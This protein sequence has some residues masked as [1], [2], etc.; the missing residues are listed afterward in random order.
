MEPEIS[1]SAL[2]RRL[3]A[4]GIEEGREEAR[5]LFSHFE[6]LPPSALYGQDPVS[7]S[8]ALLRA[9]AL[10][11]EGAPLAYLLGEAPFYRHTFLVNES[12]LIP[13]PE[14]ELL[15]ERAVSL[16]PKGGL[17]ADLGT[18]SGCIALSLLAERPDARAL[19]LDVSKGALAVA[20]ENACRLSLLDRVTFLEADL[21]APLPDFLTSVSLD[22]VLSNPPYIRSSV[23]KTLSREV[24]REPA[25]ALC[26]GEDGMLFYRR[27]LPAFLPRLSE[28]GFFLFECGFDQEREMAALSREY[29]LLFTPYFD[30]AGLFR[31]A[32]LKRK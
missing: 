30:Y 13:R 15:V 3:L 4:A 21:L 1:L 17:F 12:C 8:A 7:R 31:G 6:G 19:A 10:R 11:E 20:R 14:T 29:G 25:S 18:G 16:L 28:E 27:I 26:G 23:M 5:R 2:A 22:A 24:K 32:L 9:A